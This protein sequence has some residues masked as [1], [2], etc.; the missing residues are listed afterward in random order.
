MPRIAG[1]TELIRNW[2]KAALAAASDETLNRDNSTTAAPSRIP[3]PAIV[4]GTKLTNAIMG[5]VRNIALRNVFCVSRM[6]FKEKH[7]HSRET[8]KP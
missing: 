2:I 3:I 5:T 6:G 8:N 4:I 7:G 1:I